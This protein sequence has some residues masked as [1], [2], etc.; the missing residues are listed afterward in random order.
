MKPLS[1]RVFLGSLGLIAGGLGPGSLA[2][3]CGGKK[4][5]A[6]PVKAELVRRLSGVHNF[7]TT[8]F[9]PNYELDADGLRRNVADHARSAPKDMTI[10]VAGGLGELFT[11]S[12]P[13]HKRLVAAAVAGAQ[14]KLPVV[15]G[16]GGGYKNALQMAQNAESAGADAIFIFPI[17]LPATTPK[18]PTSICTTSRNLSESVRWLIRAERATFGRTC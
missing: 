7:L 14:R 12:V 2:V 15:A 1:R 5:G 11:L 18:G 17:R 13:E 10:V 9:R 4:R 6:R 8:P 16:V 3:V